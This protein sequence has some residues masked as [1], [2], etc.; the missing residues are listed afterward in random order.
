MGIE[1]TLMQRYLFI[2][3]PVIAV[4]AVLVLSKKHEIFMSAMTYMIGTAITG[5]F[6]FFLI[7]LTKTAF[8]FYRIWVDR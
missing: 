3:I 1:T 6:I 5:Y 8:I 2:V 4:V 7:F